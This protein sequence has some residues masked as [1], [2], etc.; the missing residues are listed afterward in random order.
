MLEA[1]KGSR[2]EARDRCLILL[3]YRHG[4]RV[5]EACGLKLDQID[6]YS[7]MIY[8]SRLK[9]SLSTTQPLRGAKLRAIGAWMKE[10]LRMAPGYK[11]FFIS[12]RRKPMH[13]STV[14]LLVEKYAV[15]SGLS[16]HAHP[17]MVRHACGFAL[18]DQGADTRLIQDYLGHRIF[19]TPCAIRRRIRRGSSGCGG[20]SRALCR[21]CV[22]LN[23]R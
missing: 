2:N 13:C 19:N 14:N 8:I 17:R 23:L 1:T 20:E 10:R 3:L 4:V 18:A 11:A 12:E 7:R 22:R 16:I 15:A 6:T 5:S 9:G 21:R